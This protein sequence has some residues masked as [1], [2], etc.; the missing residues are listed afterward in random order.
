MTHRYLPSAKNS[1]I[2]N[3]TG[4]LLTTLILLLAFALGANGLNRD[5]I[6]TDELYSVSN[7]GRF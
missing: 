7:M 5:I 1:D 6:W 3:R 2:G 4:L